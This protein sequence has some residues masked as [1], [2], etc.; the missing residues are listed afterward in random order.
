MDTE[1]RVV[2][3]G[4]AAGG[5]EALTQFFAN[6]PPDPG[7]AF[8]VVLHLLPGHASK[9][10][11]IIA[12]ATGM[13]VEQ[14]VD[15]AAIQRNRVYVIAPDMLLRVTD[16][17]LHVRAPIAA[18]H[19]IMSVDVL[20]S[21][22]AAELGP[23]AIG[24]VLSGIGADGALGLKAIKQAGG[25]TVAQ[26]VNGSAPQYGEMPAA[27]IASASVDLILPVEQMGIRLA[28]LA[29]PPADA[30]DAAL[31]PSD[32]QR[33]A[34]LKPLICALLR[35]QIG[36]DFSG[37]RRD[38][39]MR[40]VH[41]RTQFLG[42]DPNGYV[43]RLRSDPHEVT[44]LFHDQL[45][46]VTAFFRDPDVFEAISQTVIPRLLSG[47][48]ADGTVRIWVP[49]CATGEEAYSLA[50]ILREHM[51]GMV[52]PP[53]IQIFATDLDEAAIALARAGR[54]P[55][56]LTKGVSAERLARF[57]MP[58]DSGFV[59]GRAI[60]ELCTFSVHSVIRDPPFSRM[61]MVSCRNL[62]IYLDSDLQ[63]RVLRTF[64][65]AL[66]PGG[67]L[68]LGGSETV[69]RN[70]ELFLSLDR[71][72]RIF[73]RRKGEAP[74]PIAEPSVQP[75]RA[76]PGS[77]V[78]RRDAPGLDLAQ[79]ANARVLDRFAPAFV[80]VNANGEVLHFSSR[81][82]RYLEA[83]PGVPSRSLVAM[84]R[85]GLR[86]DL[87]ATLRSAI[88][89]GEPVVR[90]PVQVEVDG[91][92]VDISL[93]V[94]PLSQDEAERLYLVVFSDIS[95]VRPRDE[96]APP[97]PP[98]VT[99]E[100]FE[101][102]LR[103]TRE[104]LQSTMEEHET[105][106]E[107]LK[108]SNEELHSVNE[109]LQSTNEELETSKE[110]IQSM[111]EELE[112]VNTQLSGKIEELDRTN[113]DLRNVFESTKVATIFLDRFMVVRSFTPAVVGVYNLIAGDIGRP[114][115]DITSQLNYPTIETDFAHVLEA[116]QPLERRITRRD[117]NTHYLMRIAP[118][119]TAEN[120][121]DGALLTFVD[122]SSVVQTEQYNRLLVDEV[123]QRVSNMLALVIAL[124]EH[125]LHEAVTLEAF[126]ELYLRRV[127]VLASACAL[128]GRGTGE[129]V[130]L[131]DVIASE[132][133]LRGSGREASVTLKGPDVPVTPRRALAIGIVMHEL[134]RN[135]A[136]VG[137]LSVPDGT[138]GVR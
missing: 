50:I 5:V 30:D 113:A 19:G 80:V 3:I 125:T 90:E 37:Y 82:F 108:S 59:V 115:T 22:M 10:P 8:L 15:G 138:V 6:V 117:G 75:G 67:I 88:D 4:A 12:R 64:S 39:F 130:Q 97:V 18:L 62:L 87:R 126:S 34:D 109:E 86:L 95:A 13:T 68:V 54:Y 57:F 106:L 73:Q 79:R 33:I 28:T 101:R 32:E 7:M 116:L 66:S 36:H 42:L 70:G 17:H 21:S 120:R 112:T 9:L 11:E 47:K 107:E 72:S 2:G 98:D 100:Q 122:V 102:E 121:V 74:P 46:G 45:I 89:S 63:A 99:V 110:E 84:A 51:A 129:Q 16:N 48:A 27:A 65:Y 52:T 29:L 137:A 69:N 92:T 49:G 61:D 91:G 24:V 41:R 55:A 94:E 127:N 60:R 93:T 35:S 133:P 114:L 104:E 135:A 136:S 96:T 119:R 43:A 31:P 25:V 56:P 1:L 85:R 134:A 128:L 76:G 38:T 78:R 131:R 26:G 53:R 81:T 111:N 58:T 23:R 118:Y 44:L 132:V 123:N 83:A 71:K 14:A 77:P 20:F 124:V 105:A 103:E 40:R